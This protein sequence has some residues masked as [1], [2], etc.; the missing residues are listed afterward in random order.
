[1]MFRWRRLLRTVV[2]GTA[3]ALMAIGLAAPALAEPATTVAYPAWASATRF[4]GLAFDAC[5]APSLAKMQAWTAASNPPA[6]YHAIGV[7]VG[8][9]TRTCDQPELTSSWVAAV[10]AL[11]WRLIPIFKGRQP[12]CG[13]RPSDL[14]I[15]PSQAASEG[16]WAAGNASAKVKALGMFKGSAIYYD[17]EHYTTTNI[18]CRT[19]VLTFLS[20]WTKRLHALGYVSGVYENLNLGARDLAN[21]YT[22]KLYARPDAL[23]IARNDQ[24]PALTGWVGIPDDLW[25]VHQ[26]AKQYHLDFQATYGG[27]TLSIDADSVN[28][29]VATTAFGYLSTATIRARSGPGTS[30][31]VIKVYPAGAGMTVVCQAPGSTVGTTKVWDK[32]GDGTYVPDYYVNTPSKTTYSP[33]VTR[34]LYPY[35]VTASTGASERSGPGTSYRITGKLANGALAWVVCQKSGSAVGSTRIWDQ[36]SYQHW[37]SDNYV[38]TPSVTGYSKPIP[39]C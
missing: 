16:T 31:P 13:G 22:S 18:P 3:V 4:N 27:V 7:Y 2:A 5:T 33:P 38:A 11:G 8:G 15:V 26:R 28:A 30:Y 23:W 24:N 36:I 20:A 19:A 37:V 12:P 32:L 39:R 1:M 35:Q 9:Q 10:A 17:M 21:V 25:S 34:C 14:K 6:P 29:P